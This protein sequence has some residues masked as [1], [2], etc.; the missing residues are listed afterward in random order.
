MTTNE[1]RNIRINYTFVWTTDQRDPKVKT[2]LQKVLKMLGNPSLI[3]SKENDERRIFTGNP[4]LIVSKEN[5]ERRISGGNYSKIETYKELIDSNNSNLVKYTYTLRLN[6][7]Q[8]NEISKNISQIAYV[9]LTFGAEI[10]SEEIMR[11]PEYITNY[12]SCITGYIE[13]YFNLKITNILETRFCN[14]ENENDMF[15]PVI[16]I[17]TPILDNG[18]AI[19]RRPEQFIEIQFECQYEKL[20]EWKWY[21]TNSLGELAISKMKVRE[22]DYKIL[23]GD[24]IFGK[25][26]D[27]DIF[28]DLKEIIKKLKNNNYFTVSK[29]ETPQ[30]NEIYTEIANMMGLQRISSNIFKKNVLAYPV[31]DLITENWMIDSL[32]RICNGDLPRIRISGW[33][34]TVDYIYPFGE[35][36]MDPYIARL[37]YFA[38]KTYSQ[39]TN[40]NPILKMFLPFVRVLDD[41]TIEIPITTIDDITFFTNEFPDSYSKIG[42]VSLIPCKNIYT[43]ILIRYFLSQHLNT[44]SIYIP[45]KNQNFVVTNRYIADIQIPKDFALEETTLLSSMR[46][47]TG[48]TLATLPELIQYISVPIKN[49]DVEPVKSQ[50]VYLPIQQAEKFEISNPDFISKKLYHSWSLKGLFPYELIPNMRSLMN[51]LPMKYLISPPNGFHLKANLYKNTKY[52]ITVSR[53][54]ETEEV[55]EEE[56]EEVE[57]EEEDKVIPFLEVDIGESKNI[58]DIVQR[59]NNV[60]KCGWFFSSWATAMIWKLNRISMNIQNS[61]ILLLNA[62]T[63]PEKNGDNIPNDI[64]ENKII[65]EMQKWSLVS[66]SS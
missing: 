29:A 62:V 42:N 61:N 30:I 48:N 18:S 66:C 2:Q 14:V 47:I 65:H 58:E 24:M 60:F 15:V 33:W 23:Y 19:Y 56:V 44:T 43:S 22:E 5:D 39:L 34:T 35:E 21:L 6:L 53:E 31:H 11:Y 59:F 20:K 63:V 52:L 46:D 36:Q 25:A 10:F 26:S 3:V 40:V 28:N 27:A 38:Y 4:S 41:L 13:K 51:E 32:D 1:N 9:P 54:Q 55:E 17:F 45:V 12:K 37:Q 57:E 16:L 64:N 50:I 49:I 8:I 7:D